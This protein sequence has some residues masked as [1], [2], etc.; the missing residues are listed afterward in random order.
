MNF[1]SVSVLFLT[2]TLQHHYYFFPST[3]AQNATMF[4]ELI[5]ISLAA[6]SKAAESAFDM[7]TAG[8]CEDC[9]VSLTS[10]G[11]GY[12]NCVIYNSADIFSSDLGFTA[13]DGG[14]V[15]AIAYI[16]TIYANAMSVGG[17][18]F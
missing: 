5:I 14:Y 8:T 15:I 9:P 11:T 16:R 7:C 6:F 13:S 18:H 2:T 4:T 17:C 12:P 1:D 3:Y 10:A